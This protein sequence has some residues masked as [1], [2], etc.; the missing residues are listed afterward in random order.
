LNSKDKYEGT[1]IGLSIAKKIIEKHNGL[2]T[3]KSKEGSGAEFKI[4]LPVKQ[5][6][7]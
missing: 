7:I 1:G 2:I 3:A 4:I 6:E 5:N